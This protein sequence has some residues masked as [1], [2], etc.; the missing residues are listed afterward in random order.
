MSLARGASAQK[1]QE[2]LIR[3]HRVKALEPSQLDA[4]ELAK[5]LRSHLLIE[6]DTPINS[7]GDRFGFN[8]DYI[9]WVERGPHD[10]ILWVNHEYPDPLSLH[11]S[12]YDH[13]ELRTRAQIEIERK[14]VGGTLLRIRRAASGKPWNF[15]YDDPLNRRIDATTPIPFAWPEKMA[16][17]HT[18]TGTL[19][20]CAGGK[21][22][23][24]T[25]LSC[26]E[27]YP[28]V[29][30]DKGKKSLY[31]WEHHLDLPSEHYGWVVEINPLTGAA[32]KLVALGRFFHEG[33]T[34]ARAKNGRAVIYMGDDRTDQCVYKFISDRSDSLERG[35]LYV[36]NLSSGRWI[37]LKRE[38]HPELKKRFAT[39]TDVLIHAREAGLLAGGTTLDRPEDIEIDPVTGA[40]I[41]ACTNNKDQGQI[42]RAHV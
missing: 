13:P 40:V 28:D 24:G 15:V 4:L 33:A 3:G 27:N 23:W 25:V 1:T 31:G 42:G 39:E 17:A 32:K 30:P 9:A 5:G 29:I 22:P 37:P 16:G 19:G 14:A 18:A 21:T 10:A 7:R 8:N 35:T 36:A 26:E 6:W 12:D 2:I 34:Y 11:G 20:N 41:I 38:T